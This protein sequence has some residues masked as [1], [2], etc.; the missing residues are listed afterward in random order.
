MDAAVTIHKL[1]VTLG[2]DFSALREVTVDLPTGKIIGFIG[3]SG[4]GK[5]TLIR[6][7][8]GRQRLTEGS[9]NVFGIPAGDKKLRGTVSYMTQEVSVYSDLTAQENIKYFATMV[10]IPR[11]QLAREIQRVLHVVDL[12]AQK[13]QIVHDMSGGQKQRVS[14]AISLLG[15]PKLMVLDEPTVG[16][17]PLLREQLWDIF[18]ELARQ[19]TTL[20]ISSHV[21]DEAERC[22]ELLLIRGGQIL[23]SGTPKELCQRTGAR[24]VE[25]SFLQLVGE[26]R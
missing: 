13:N 6:S 21:M 7:I 26:K 5:T 16:L 19:G 8:V 15:S 17:D 10:G 12:G 3:P 2:K 11:K 4:A 9:I 23:A 22:D 25:E 14:L 24:S 1:S 20:I 18:H